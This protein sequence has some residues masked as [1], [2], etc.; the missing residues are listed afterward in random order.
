MNMIWNNPSIVVIKELY[1]QSVTNKEKTRS[2]SKEA[3]ELEFDVGFQQLIYSSQLCNHNIA[4]KLDFSSA[5]MYILIFSLS[6]VF[7]LVSYFSF[8]F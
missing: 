5:H 3:L 4:P 7:F 2:H 6:C 1:R 8:C